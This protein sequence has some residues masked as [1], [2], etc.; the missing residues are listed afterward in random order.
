MLR[1]L[2]KSFLVIVLGVFIYSAPVSAQQAWVDQNPTPGS[3]SLWRGVHF[4]DSAM[5]WIVGLSGRISKTENAGAT[6]VS[7][8]S[9]TTVDLLSARFVSATTGVAVGQSGAIRRTTD[10]GTTWVVRTSGTMNTLNDVFFVSATTGWAVGNNGIVLR[11][12][13]AGDTWTTQFSDAG[14]TLT[15]IHFVSDTLGWVV[16]F[17]GSLPGATGVIMRTTDGGTTWTA[18]LSGP[19]TPRFRSVFFPTATWGWAVGDGGAIRRTTDGGV[20][21]V[22]QTSSATGTLQD[23]FFASTSTGYIVG[24]DGTILRTTT[25][26]SPWTAEPTAAGVTLYEVHAVSL[27]LAWAVGDAGRIMRRDNIA[28]S[29]PGDLAIRSPDS[30]RT[31]TFTW[32]AATDNV[33]VIRYTVRLASET[34]EV[35]INNLDLGVALSY[36]VQDAAPLDEGTT[37]SFSVQATDAAGNKSGSVEIEFTVFGSPDTDA[38]TVP[39]NLTRTTLSTDRTP[40]FTWSASIDDVAIETYEVRIDGGAIQ[41][42]IPSATT[43]TSSVTLP[44]GE[45]NIQVRALDTAGNNST[46][47]TLVFDLTVPSEEDEGEDGEETLSFDTV[48]TNQPAATTTSTSATFEF[49]VPPGTPVDG[50]TFE[51]AMDGGL[52]EA[53]TSPRALTGLALGAHTFQARTI[54]GGVPD[55]TPASYSWTI[56]ATVQDGGGGGGGGGIP[57]T[58]GGGGGGTSTTTGSSGST[59]T[60]TTASSPSGSSTTNTT[61]S[62]TSTASSAASATRPPFALAQM[63]TDAG[64]V[65]SADRSVLL[66]SLGF[67]DILQCG[68]SDKA[69]KERVSNTLGWIQGVEIYNAIV[70]FTLC[71]TATT[72]HLGAGE[73]LGAVNSYKAALGRLPSTEAHWFDVMKIANGRFPGETSLTAEAAAKTRF[74]RI[75]LRDPN[76][77]VQS[78]KAAVNVMAYGLRPLPRNV[79]SERVAIVTFKAIFRYNPSSA[80]DWDAVRAIGYSGARR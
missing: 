71:G 54:T 74:K 65:V 10:G 57:V 6:W 42:L 46:W 20:T 47:A 23:V 22:V 62:G 56:N 24:A 18:Q 5:G 63:Q 30:D 48:I 12:T 80:S 13:D 77:G 70:N 28:P 69:A 14:V 50:F 51:C 52:F 21:W 36:T 8:A 78:D 38:P 68:L 55:P 25:V 9:G 76:M 16:G 29:L 73:R 7:Q 43:Y 17:E 1:F 37:Y 59:T 60:G 4:I 2:T 79:N 45:H 49:G 53:C 58:Q 72:L 11:T 75:Y 3:G 41:Y 61:A 26:G 64:L 19:G 34:D 33:G 67:S 40:T 15:G 32:S 39:T 27:G 44:T 35:I 31:P 66:G